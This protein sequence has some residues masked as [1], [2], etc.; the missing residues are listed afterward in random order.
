MRSCVQLSG[1]YY[2]LFRMP[3]RLCC[4][5]CR[6]WTPQLRVA[7]RRLFVLIFSCCAGLKHAKLSWLIIKLISMQTIHNLKLATKQVRTD[8]KLFSLYI[9]LSKKSLRGQFHGTFR[10]SLS[11]HLA[12]KYMIKYQTKSKVHASNYGEN[13]TS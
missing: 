9:K 6:T 3:G 4:G 2:A 13:C 7:L 11:L 10:Q 1:A 8:L 5:C 12:V